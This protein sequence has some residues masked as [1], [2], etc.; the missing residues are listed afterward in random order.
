MT[1]HAGA[2][3]PGG[4]QNAAKRRLGIRHAG[5]QQTRVRGNDR[6]PGFARRLR[7]DMQRVLVLA[8]DIGVKALLF[9]YEYRGA[10]GQDAVQLIGLE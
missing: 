7:K 10:S 2:A 6:L 1:A 5:R 4:G 3:M 9:E 8:V